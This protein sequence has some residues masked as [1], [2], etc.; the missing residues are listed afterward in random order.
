MEAAERT[1]DPDALIVFLADDFEMLQDGR[2]VDRAATVAQMRAT[3]PTL[4]EFTPRFDD[5]RVIVLDRD[6]ALSSLIFHDDLVDEKGKRL[7]MWGPST[8]LWQRRAGSW[9]MVFADSDHYPEA[10]G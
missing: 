10:D 6:T 4:R 8:M 5:L 9:K 1:R 7:R 3:L 2:R